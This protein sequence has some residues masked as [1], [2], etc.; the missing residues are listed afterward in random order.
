VSTPRVSDDSGIGHSQGGLLTGH[1]CR[2]PSDGLER[3][4]H[5]ATRQIDSRRSN[6]N[7]ARGGLHQTSTNV[8]A[9]SSSP[10]RIAELSHRISA[11]TELLGRFLTSPVRIVPTGV[12]LARMPAISRSQPTQS[13][14]GPQFGMSQT[15][16]S[17]KRC[18]RPPIAWGQRHSIIA[19]C[20]KRTVERATT[21]SSSIRA[22]HL[23]GVDSEY[24]VRSSPSTQAN[25]TFEEVSRIL[26]H[27]ADACRRSPSA[28]RLPQ[29]SPG[30]GSTTVPGSARRRGRSDRTGT[31]NRV[32][33]SV[34]AAHCCDVTSD[35]V[36]VAIRLSR[37]SGTQE[38]IAR[39]RCQRC[40]EPMTGV[41]DGA[42]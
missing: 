41:A 40:R 34:G 2:Q 4:R 14:I 15:I 18:P 42:L 3:P 16:R 1:G 37:Q 7:C 38:G 30:R 21:M 26:C 32:V 10:R 31:G 8:R 35:T 13:R 5:Q 24:I 27:E 33:I 9:S 36:R 39:R 23:D 28:S 12:E 11:S 20:R 17:C 19:A 22:S 25:R 29:S 6:E